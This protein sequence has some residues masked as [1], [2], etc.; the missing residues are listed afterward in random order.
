MTSLVAGSVAP[1]LLA[2]AWKRASFVVMIFSIW[3]AM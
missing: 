2:M 3:M 1:V